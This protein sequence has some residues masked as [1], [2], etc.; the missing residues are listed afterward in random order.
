M[1]V[2]RDI[3]MSLGGTP[4]VYYTITADSSIVFAPARAKENSTIKLIP[5][6]ITKQIESFDMNGTTIQGDTFTM[7]SENVTITNIVLV[8]IPIPYTELEYIE[9]TG[10]QYIDTGIKATGAYMLELKYLPVSLSASDYGMWLSSGHDNFSLG[11]FNSLTR[12][13][14]RTRGSQKSNNITVSSSTP[15]ILKLMDN[16]FTYNQ[17]TLSVA[18]NQPLGSDNNNIFI[19]NQSEGGQIGV[20]KIYYLRLYDANKTLIRDFIPVLDTLG[21]PCL[22]DR[23]SETFFY[24]AGTGTF[25]YK[26]LTKLDYIESTGTQWVDTLVKGT[27]NTTIEVKIANTYSSSN[28]NSIIG[29]R[30]Y[31]RTNALMLGYYSN[32]WVCYASQESYIGNLINKTSVVKLDKNK[33]YID[34]TLVKTFSSSSFTTPSNMIIFGERRDSSVASLSNTK[35]YYCKIFENNALIRDF[36]PILDENNTPCLLD[37]VSRNYFYNSGSGTFNYGTLN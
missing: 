32:G 11:H 24:N 28:E 31:P 19:F 21:T 20:G 8:D 18:T 29:S 25:N 4:S 33:I 6:D 30:T 13:F 17:S 35:L 3:L 2:F 10:T 23:I 34:E 27:G 5:V 22:Y 36:I 1:S 37:K 16:V 9:S 12:L 26:E 15:N 7:P 14:L